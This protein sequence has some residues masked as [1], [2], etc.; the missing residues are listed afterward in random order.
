MHP[1]IK[2]FWVALGY[3]IGGRAIFLDMEGDPDDIF[4][5]ALKEGKDSFGVAHTHNKNKFQS[6][7]FLPGFGNAYEP[8]M[9]RLIKL[10]AFL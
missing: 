9:L 3:E 2:K 7:Y 8:L 6:I 10:K 1:D 4:W 5:F